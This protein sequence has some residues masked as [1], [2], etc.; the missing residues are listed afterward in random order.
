[1]SNDDK[2]YRKGRTDAAEGK[3]DPPSWGWMWNNEDTTK[4]QA[5]RELYREGRA[6]KLREMAE[7]KKK[8]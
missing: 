5:D 6:D 7:E 2:N 1:M 4:A 3:N 8:R